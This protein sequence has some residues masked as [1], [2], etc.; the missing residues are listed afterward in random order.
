M[1][2]KFTFG[3]KSVLSKLLPRSRLRFL[4]ERHDFRVRLEFLVAAE[5]VVELAVQAFQEQN[6]GRRRKGELP[7]QP[8][9]VVDARLLDEQAR[10]FCELHQETAEGDRVQNLHF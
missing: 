5:G 3:M 4:R 6:S 9:A 2:S 7:G 8:D 10:P 1:V